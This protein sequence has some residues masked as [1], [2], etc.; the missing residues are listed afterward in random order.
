M[1]LDADRIVKP[2]KK[3]RKL[4]TNL[5][6]LPTPDRVHTLRTNTRRFEATFEALSLDEQGV[7][8]S[9]MKKLG[10]CRKAAGKVRDLDVLTSYVSNVHVPGEE[11]CA[12]KLLEHL[13]SERQEH[14]A[15]L[16]RQ[17]RR[18]RSSLRK[19]LK[20]TPGVL[21]K[22]V[23]AAG[24]DP[25][26]SAA[27]PMAAAAAVR[28][29]VTLAWPPRLNRENLHP[30][31]LKVK[32]LRNVLRM[33][34]GDTP[35]F[36]KD[37][38]NVKDAIGEWHDWEELISIAEKELSGGNGC[39]LLPEF[40]RIAAEKYAHALALAETLRKDYLQRTQAQ[41][42]GAARAP[43]ALPRESVWAAV[44]RLAG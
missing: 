40:K 13:G 34:A 42:K 36:V 41:K 22:L 17:V 11:E 32:E 3:L 33:A 44:A 30:Y 37:L 19:D 29:A 7:R 6:R 23:S 12:V 14:A 4:V 20:R 1:P 24:K 18:L 35:R 25:N 43:A 16:Y 15:S 10:R 27:G 31:R 2:V 28:L 39:A 9:I 26:P 21:A 5:D 38:G 8:K